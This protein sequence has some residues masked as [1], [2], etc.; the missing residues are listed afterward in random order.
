MKYRLTS[1]Y[2]IVLVL[3]SFTAFSQNELTGTITNS[4]GT[5]IPNAGIYI[6]DL[7]LAGVTDAQGHYT[8][9]HLP[10]GSYLVTVHS[11]GYQVTSK[12]VNIH[13][14]TT[15]DFS[16]F[17]ASY[18]MQEVVV[19]GN[20]IATGIKNTSQP[21]TEIPNSY[22]LQNASTN[23]IDAISKVPGVSGITDG[24]SISKPVI[25]GLGYNRVV[26][27]NDGVR[28]EGQQWG[29][30]FG[31]EVDPNSVNR[32]EILKGPAS[33]VYGSDAIS[34]IINLL[35]DE[36]MPEGRIKGDIL[37]N[38][39]TNNGLMNTA[40][41]VAG[42]ING[43]AFSARIDNTM[44]HA[45]R[46]NNDAYVLNSQFSN[47]NTDGTIGI[48]RKWGFSQLH[49]SYFNLQTGIVEGVRDTL[50]G[51]FQLQT[52]FNG[53]APVYTTATNQQLRSYTPFLINQVVR[54]YKLVWDNSV[55]IGKSRLIA[56]LAW[57]ENRRQENNDISQPDVSNIY[58]YLNTI[59]YDLRY[60]SPTRNNF[61]FS[62]G[63]NGMYQNS[64]NKGTLLLIPEYDLFDIG[65]FAIANKKAG[66]F[67]F[68]AGIRY[69]VRKFQGHAGYTDSNENSLTYG[70]PG[71]GHQFSAY[72]SNFNGLSGSIGATYNVNDKVYVKANIG[73]GFRAPNVAETGSNGIHDGTV[74]YEIGSPA[75]QPESSLEFDL[76]PGVQTKDVTIEVSPF[77]NSIHNFIS[78]KQLLNVGGNDSVRNDITGF[79]NAPAF[80]YTQTDAI[81]TGMEAMVDIHPSGIKWFD[82][83]TTFSTVDAHLQ[84]VPANE[85]YLPF[86]PPARIRS[87]VTVTFKKLSKTF[88]N[89][90]VRFGVYYNFKQSNVYQQS[91]VY[92]G[93]SAADSLASVSPTAAYTLLNAGA[94]T[95]VMVRGHTAFSLYISI[96][97]L[98]NSSY[99][100][101]MSRFK[102]YPANVA[103][104]LDRVGVYN[105]GRNISFEILVPLDLKH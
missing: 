33:L 45:Y 32:I 96:D 79:P 95:N 71:I 22:L 38:Y 72:S 80:K 35:P 41:H 89:T 20:A 34:G 42:N 64:Q 105:M 16:L 70:Q 7:K 103:N 100:D 27:V 9:T 85:K 17:A 69:D 50:T 30:E 31:I 92:A 36:T 25:R 15:V 88:N 8:I 90:Y 13:G 76:T 53:T 49:F 43:I 104:G 94:G 57:Q 59:N 14:Y 44:A 81:L 3:L 91:Q 102:Y 62:A 12:E 26:T 65:T 78:A 11:L 82:W 48:H 24:Q 23:I 47:F 98:T 5:V 66:K 37:Y 101:Y 21:I 54:H 60:V 56:R 83:Y 87:E 97:N 10:A 51:A 1:I 19:T 28:Q 67:N 73:K 77:I 86:T 18:E 4:K 29:D 74:V 61:D 93:L 68:S 99:I 75:L 6:E 55:E 2:I 46:N 39:Q 63:A 52:G 58:Y 84:N 40:G